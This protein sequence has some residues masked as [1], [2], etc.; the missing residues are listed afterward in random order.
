MYI[1][2]ENIISNFD[3][4]RLIELVNENGNGE[5][6]DENKLQYICDYVNN[7]I[8]DSL[9]GK[10]SLPINPVP[11]TLTEIALQIAKYKI[12]E[13]R[14]AVNEVII[15]SYEMNMKLLKEYSEGRGRIINSNDD[16]T[17]NPFFIKI[18]KRER[19]IAQ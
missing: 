17:S 9:R 19:K 2:P 4:T 14:N 12:Y 6:P 3:L 8:D 15:R 16:S 18:N 1:Q 13:L 7:L 10:Y 11:V 5:T